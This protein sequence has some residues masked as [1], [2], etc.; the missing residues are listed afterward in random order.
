M[1]NEGEQEGGNTQYTYE[2]FW[3]IRQWILAVPLHGCCPCQYNH[4]NHYPLVDVRLCHIVV[5]YCN[6]WPSLALGMVK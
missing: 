3:S 4:F 1:A 2:R 5:L 6:D